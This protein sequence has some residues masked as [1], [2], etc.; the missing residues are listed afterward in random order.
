MLMK[1]TKACLI[2]LLAISLV[3]GACKHNELN[4][5]EKNNPIPNYKW[6]YNFTAKGSFDIKDTL[7]AYNIYIVL[8][9]TDAYKYNNIWLNIGLQGPADSMY[10]Q[11]VE[12]TLGSD[13]GGWEGT[14][15][16]DIWEVRKL[17]VNRPRKFIKAGTYHYSIAQIMRDNPLEKVMSAGLRVQKAIQ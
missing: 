12:L 10:F 16:N 11:K 17:L 14:G 2:L 3:L 6:D 15:L 1:N 5:F 7:C 9:H 13:A 4:F 8:R